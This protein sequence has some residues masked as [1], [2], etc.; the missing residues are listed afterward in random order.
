MQK[1]SCREACK[2]NSVVSDLGSRARSS[3][4]CIWQETPFFIIAISL[5]SSAIYTVEGVVSYTCDIPSSGEIVYLE[6]PFMAR[7][8]NLIRYYTYPDAAVE[9]VPESMPHSPYHEQWYFDVIADTFGVNMLR[10]SLTSQFVE[11][12]PGSGELDSYFVGVLDEELQ[13]CIERD[14]KVILDCH[15]WG[16]NSYQWPPDTNEM[17]EEPSAWIN[18]WDKLLGHYAA[19]G[20][21]GNPVWG[22]DLINEPSHGTLEQ[23]RNA[24]ESMLDTL[25]PK[26]PEVTFILEGLGG[27][28][29]FPIT[30]YPDWSW[31]NNW[32]TKYD[33]KILLDSHFY[34][35]WAVLA[36]EEW[37]CPTWAGLYQDGRYEEAKVQLYADLDRARAL[38][39]GDIVD[40]DLGWA[41]F[42]GGSYLPYYCGEIGCGSGID[43]MEPH[44]LHWLRDFLDYC[45]SKSIQYLF[46]RY[47]AEVNYHEW[48]CVEY[49]WKTPLPEG[50]VLIEYME[51]NP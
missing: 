35:D 6:T 40:H 41:P 42:K 30:T 47:G 1:H 16:P 39:A 18:W 20:W 33:N 11:P 51:R 31:L 10:I 28:F 12:V 32:T 4:S 48:A 34:Y 46:W 50:N 27:T 36:W 26:Y 7:G 21:L 14:I 38:Q 44:K 8:L 17:W 23:K 19:K 24:Y 22:A 2:R 25:H 37:Q 45:E 5:I 9:G 29:S 15:I 43:R 3:L 49:D 13:W